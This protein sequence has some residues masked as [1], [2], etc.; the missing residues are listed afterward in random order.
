MPSTVAA[1][2]FSL[3][4]LVVVLL[5]ALSA[6]PVRA[7][8]A[9][10]CGNST[11]TTFTLCVN[12]AMQNGNKVSV[13]AGTL[14]DAACADVQANQPAYFCCLCNNW[15]AVHSCHTQ[16]CPT[17]GLLTSVEQQE[18]QFCGACTA[19]SPSTSRV[20]AATSSGPAAAAV[21][22]SVL[23]SSAASSAPTAAPTGTDAPTKNGA[24]ASVSAG[25]VYG[26]AV[27]A[28]AAVAAAGLVLA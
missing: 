10:D 12:N 2:R 4:L 3:L 1:H 16:L 18:L 24:A 28:L 17:S 7:Q 15:R 26:A 5:A 13:G 25:G 6:S 27:L 8:L 23:V 11:Q 14:P 21:S 22:T 9:T 20:A 19:A